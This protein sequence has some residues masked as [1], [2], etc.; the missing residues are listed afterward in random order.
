MLVPAEVEG[1]ELRDVL[2]CILQLRSPVI[3]MKGM[4]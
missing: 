3:S 4:E 2:G 1:L